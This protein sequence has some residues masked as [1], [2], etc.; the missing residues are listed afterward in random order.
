MAVEKMNQTQYAKWVKMTQP[1]IA[2]RIR[3]N[4]PLRGVIE[5]EKLGRMYVL[6]VDKNAKT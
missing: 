1:A 2:Y 3:K 5:I 4:L 6:T